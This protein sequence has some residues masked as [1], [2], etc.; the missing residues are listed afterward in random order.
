MTFHVSTS[1]ELF[2]MKIHTSSVVSL[3]MPADL[4]VRRAIALSL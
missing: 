4:M 2:S 3:L 1:N